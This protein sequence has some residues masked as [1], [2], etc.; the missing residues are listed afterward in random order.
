LN[1]VE[2]YEKYIASPHHFAE[3]HFAFQSRS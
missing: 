3:V 2:F 1:N